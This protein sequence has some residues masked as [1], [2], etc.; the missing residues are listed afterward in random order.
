MRN[1]RHAI[2]VFALLP[3]TIA[4][5]GAACS[6]KETGSSSGT[7]SGGTDGG[8]SDG[9]TEDSGT[10]DTGADSGP[11]VVNNCKTF[12]DRTGSGATRTIAWQ[13]PIPAADR[14]VRIKKGQSVT[15]NGN[16]TQY[17]V[18]PSAGSTQPNPIASFDESSPTVK[19]PNV[20][21]YGFECP[22]APALLGAIDV[23]E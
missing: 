23:V 13:F 5:G 6:S 10:A 22:D 3:V 1:M 4:M 12:D 21:T 17:R 7:S 15:F 20:G 18:A 8:G 16:F 2:V 14:C 11:L 19:F 9:S